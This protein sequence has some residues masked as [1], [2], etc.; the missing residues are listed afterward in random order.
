[1]PNPLPSPLSWGDCEGDGARPALSLCLNLGGLLRLE[2]AIVG[3]TP[4][5]GG[6]AF[7]FSSPSPHRIREFSEVQL[8]DD[9]CWYQPGAAEAIAS[10]DSLDDGH[11]YCWNPA[12]IR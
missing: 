6:N 8:L 2:S 5:Y 1:M 10:L 4:V 12:G 3:S 9:P 7:E 11:K